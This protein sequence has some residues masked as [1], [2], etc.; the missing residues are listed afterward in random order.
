MNTLKVSITTPYG[1]IFDGE[2]DYVALPGAEGEFG[3]ISGHS[4]ML[5]L[6]K[7]GIIELNHD[8][9]RNL[10]AINWGYAKVESD[11]V[12][13]LIDGAVLIN[14]KTSKMSQA[15]EDAKRLLEEAS[16]DKVAFSSVVSKIDSI[17][18]G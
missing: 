9:D 7:T 15:I 4:S 17:A 10:V 12:D 1:M 16:N 13:I 2:A 14:N 6:L 18:K 5:A 11:R 3:V 8:A